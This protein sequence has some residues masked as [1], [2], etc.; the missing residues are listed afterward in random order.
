MEKGLRKSRFRQ[1]PYS[2]RQPLGPG[3]AFIRL[4]FMELSISDLV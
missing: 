4:L 3:P 2:Y 1:T